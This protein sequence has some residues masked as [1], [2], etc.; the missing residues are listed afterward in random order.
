MIPGFWDQAL[1]VLSKE[2]AWGSL[3][4]L[5]TLNL[6]ARYA[7]PLYKINCFLKMPSFWKIKDTHYTFFF[8]RFFIY[9]LERERACTSR[10]EA[11]GKE[12]A[13]SLLSWE[14]DGL[15][16]RTWRS[17]PELKADAY[18]SEPSR[19]PSHI[20]LLTL[21]LSK[22]FLTSRY[23]YIQVF[24]VWLLKLASFRDI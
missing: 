20:T 4:L 24:N 21:H 19:C 16:P 15:N 17:W 12:E 7:L 10:V 8:L 22:P 2:S 3:P 11:E 5:P 18:P 6:C 1:S 9:S 14:P 13:N 23:F